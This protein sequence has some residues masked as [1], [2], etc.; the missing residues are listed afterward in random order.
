MRS[1]PGASHASFCLSGRPDNPANSREMHTKVL[2]NLMVA[3]LA[4]LISR[5]HRRI[6]VG[7]LCFDHGQRWRT[8]LRTRYIDVLGVALEFSLLWATNRSSPR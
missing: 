1:L 6:S 8:A 2:S 3:I 5:Y 4:G 7:V